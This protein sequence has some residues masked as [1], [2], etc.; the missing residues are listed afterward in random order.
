M[1]Q[2]E[3]FLMNAKWALRMHALAGCAFLQ[4]KAVQAADGICATMDWARNY[5][6]EVVKVGKLGMLLSIPR[7]HSANK[8]TLDVFPCL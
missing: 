6:V 1:P 7:L 3:S 4:A 5:K 2:K 8:V